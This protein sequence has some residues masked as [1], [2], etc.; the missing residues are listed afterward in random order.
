MRSCGDERSIYDGE[1]KTKKDESTLLNTLDNLF[2]SF[3]INDN[4][5]T[6]LRHLAIKMEKCT[7]MSS[8]KCSNTLKQFVGN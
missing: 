5:N 6:A 7:Y 4:A 3:I 2:Y 1:S 8:T